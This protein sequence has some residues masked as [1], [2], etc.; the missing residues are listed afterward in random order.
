MADFQL[1]LEALAGDDGE[2][3]MHGW[4]HFHFFLAPIR[5]QFARRAK[6]RCLRGQSFPA[7]ARAIFTGGDR[8]SDEIAIPLALWGGSS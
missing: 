7:R 5:Q 6:Q 4:P 2:R 1:E 3:V 8:A